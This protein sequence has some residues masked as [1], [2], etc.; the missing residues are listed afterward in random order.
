MRILKFKI[1]RT[2]YLPFIRPRLEYTEVVGNNCTQYDSIEL[3][4][5]QNEAARIVTGAT[6]LHASLSDNI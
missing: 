1:N 5:I 6:E 4:K 3:D 2:V